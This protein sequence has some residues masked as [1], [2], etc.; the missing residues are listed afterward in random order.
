MHYATMKKIAGLVLWAA[1]LAASAAAFEDS[2]AQ[3]TLACTGCH[4]HQGKSGPD[5]Y[6]PRLAG[7][8]AG[9]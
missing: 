5:G 3:R 8:P 9:Y 2:M 7:K 1:S 6:Y 4:G